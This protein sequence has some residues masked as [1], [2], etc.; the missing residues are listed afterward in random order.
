MADSAGDTRLGVRA[1]ARAWPRLPPPVLSG[2]A[3][4][5]VLLPPPPPCKL[6]TEEALGLGLEARAPLAPSSEAPEVGDTAL[7]VRKGSVSVPQQGS[8]NNT[9]SGEEQVW[10]K[11][12][13]L[14]RSKGG[15]GPQPRASLAPVHSFPQDTCLGPARGHT[16]QGAWILESELQVG[17][18]PYRPLSDGSRTEPEEEEPA[19]NKLRTE[20]RS[21]SSRSRLALTGGFPRRGR[22]TA[23]PA[24]YLFR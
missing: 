18:G 1:P 7:A 3:S 13:L 14:C 5:A 11:T 9:L 12:T 8:R 2:S 6:R 19:P 21:A 23:S 20:P 17:W 24:T 10:L 15:N 22:Q 4:P 16:G